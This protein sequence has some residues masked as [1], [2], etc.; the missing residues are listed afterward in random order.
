VK[1][2]L[3]TPHQALNSMT[4][5]GIPAKSKKR[6]KGEAQKMIIIDGVVIFGLDAASQ[7][8]PQQWPTLVQ[9]IPAIQQ[10]EKRTI[11]VQL[12]HPLIVQSPDLSLYVPWDGGSETISFMEL[13]F[14]CPIGDPLRKAWIYHAHNSPHRQNPFF[15]EIITSR[16]SNLKPFSD[17][18]LHLPRGTYL[19]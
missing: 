8:L 3:T 7:T 1:V 11:N 4:P 2:G 5:K 9:F 12:K 15:A 14:E 17:C 13:E 6:W 16:I 19:I 10:C 18:R